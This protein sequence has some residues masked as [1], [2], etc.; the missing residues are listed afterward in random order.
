MIKPKRKVPDS[1]IPFMK[2]KGENHLTGKAAEKPKEP[3]DMSGMRKYM[4]DRASRIMKSGQ[5]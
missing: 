1:F 4:M 3:T 5:A 2:K